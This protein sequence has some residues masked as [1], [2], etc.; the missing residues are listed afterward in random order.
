MPQRVAPATLRRGRCS[1]PVPISVLG[2]P[3]DVLFA[4]K[5]RS[6]RNAP[7]TAE[8]FRSAFSATVS[9][10]KLL[11]VVDVHVQW[12]VW[13]ARA[14]DHARPIGPGANHGAR[15]EPPK[16]LRP[17]HELHARI[18]I[19]T[20]RVHRYTRFAPACNE[21][22]SSPRTPRSCFRNW[23]GAQAA[24]HMRDTEFAQWSSVRIAPRTHV[25]SAW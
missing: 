18:A 17:M 1:P 10:C 11:R 7:A 3:V 8:V 25:R 9:I 16:E 21:G 15:S 6:R 2:V 19:R 23:L 20:W 14:Y 24:S 22:A 5:T 12:G 4:A 13:F